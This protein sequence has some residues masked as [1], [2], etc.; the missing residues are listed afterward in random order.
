MTI[1]FIIKL[2]SSSDYITEEV[3]DLILIIVDRLTKY[4]YFILYKETYTAE[5]LARIVIDRLVR[6]M[7]YLLRLLQTGTNFLRQITGKLLLHQSAFDIS[8]QP[9]STHRQTDRR[10][11]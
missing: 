3:Y 4:T 5:Q 1:D 6:Y 2:L 11:E 7:E 8:Y 10:N 9:R